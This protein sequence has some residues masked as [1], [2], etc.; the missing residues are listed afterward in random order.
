M[1][2]AGPAVTANPAQQHMAMVAALPPEVI[3][4]LIALAQAAQAAGS[5]PVPADSNPTTAEARK[6]KRKPA[7]AVGAAEL[8]CAAV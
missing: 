5:L 1:T 7:G 2:A 3:A 8:G 4:K 6:A